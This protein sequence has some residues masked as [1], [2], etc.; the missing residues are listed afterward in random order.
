MRKRAES[1]KTNWIKQKKIGIN[2][3]SVEARKVGEPIV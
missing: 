2:F 1:W 3:R